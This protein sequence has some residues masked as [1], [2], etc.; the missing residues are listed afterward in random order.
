M[1]ASG[2]DAHWIRPLPG[3]GNM[4]GIS[5]EEHVDTI[6]SRGRHVGSGLKTLRL[7]P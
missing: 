3:H 4:I 5:M 1:R 6:P 7:E 2:F